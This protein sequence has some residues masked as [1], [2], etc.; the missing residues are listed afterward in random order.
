[1][2]IFANKPIPIGTY[3]TGT[4]NAI[5]VR[6]GE[7][8][9]NDRLISLRFSTS[10]QEYSTKMVDIVFLTAF[11]RHNEDFLYPNQYGGTYFPQLTEEIMKAETPEKMNMVFK[12]YKLK[13]KTLRK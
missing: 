4:G 6:Q 11:L 1:M 7:K 9:E 13:N 5:E 2:S 12:K 3:P 10:I 8:N